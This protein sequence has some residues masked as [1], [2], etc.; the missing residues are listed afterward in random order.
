MPAHQWLIC[1]AIILHASGEGNQ[2]LISGSSVGQSSCMQVGRAIS[3]HA[4]TTVGPATV[5]PER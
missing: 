5:A 3:M 4:S 1:R 2:W